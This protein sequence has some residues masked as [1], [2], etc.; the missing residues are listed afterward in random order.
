MTAHLPCQSHL[1][2]L[3]GSHI[4][5]STPLA[6]LTAAPAAGFHC[7]GWQRGMLPIKITATCTLTAVQEHIRYD[8]M[9]GAHASIHYE[10]ACS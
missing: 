4:S 9:F 7:E 3:V 10:F 5:E 1:A 2:G 8:S 6:L